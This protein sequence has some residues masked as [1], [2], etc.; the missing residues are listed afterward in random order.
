[1][2]AVDVIRHEFEERHVQA[3]LLW[4]CAMTFT[5]VDLP[6]TGLLPASLVAGRQRRGW[7]IPL[8]GSG[9]LTDA[10]VAVIEDAGGTVLGGREVTRLVVEG[11]RCTGVETATGE[12]FSARR[13]VVSSIHVRHLLEMAPAEVWDDDLRHGVATLHPGIPLFAIHMITSQPPVFAGEPPWATAVSSGLAGWP[14]DVVDNLRAVRDGRPERFR[15]TPW[16][17]VA[18][19]TLVD[20]G[21]AP[22]GRHTVKVVV[23]APTT[24]PD[25][26]PAWDDASREAHADSVLEAVARAVPNLAGTRVLARAVH[27]PADIAADNLHML[28]G[29]AHGGDRITPFDGPQRP[30]PGWADHRMPLAGLYQT[31]GTTP[32]GGSI[33]GIPGRNAARVVLHDLGDD[34]DAVVARTSPAGRSRASTV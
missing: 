5:S 10:L 20:P 22:A 19:P 13:A 24:P 21:R 17:L 8:G 2:S 12:R 15:G 32:P 6:G 9:R 23:P 18:T 14:Q 30:A 27:S 3:F 11:G 4:L 7:S 26:S 33:T 1:M 25:G 34:L 29:A 16:A 31:G 28:G